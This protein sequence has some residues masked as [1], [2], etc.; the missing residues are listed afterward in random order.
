MHSTSSTSKL[1]AILVTGFPRSGT[2]IVGRVLSE[3]SGIRQLF[4]PYH[5]ALGLKSWPTFWTYLSD[6]DPLADDFASSFN[7]LLFTPSRYRKAYSGR[8]RY[9]EL[10]R[11]ARYI[12]GNRIQQQNNKALKEGLLPHGRWLIKDPHLTFVAGWLHRR[13]GIPVVVLHRHPGAVVASWKRLGFTPI[14]HTSLKDNVALQEKLPHLPWAQLFTAN[15]FEEIVADMW[16]CSHALLEIEE[17]EL[18]GLL[19]VEQEEL[20]ADP[21]TEFARIFETLG[22][23]MSNYIQSIIRKLTLSNVAIPDNNQVHSLERD[24]RKISQ[25]WRKHLTTHELDAIRRRVE[26]HVEGLKW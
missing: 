11:I 15:S 25:S 24:S 6:D 14:A 13:F 3:A 4:E 9:G 17:R 23:P 8:S 10:G 2:T 18:P 19:R 12:R 1:P 16:L 22:L 26:P 7:D 5:P 20:A 21:E